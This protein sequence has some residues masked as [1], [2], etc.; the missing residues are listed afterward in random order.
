MEEKKDKMKS[1]N[2]N[3]CRTG[4]DGSAE[5]Q[6]YQAGILTDYEMQ[7]YKLILDIAPRGLKGANY[8]LRLG[9]GHYVF[10]KAKKKK[11]GRWSTVWLDQS[12]DKLEERNKLNPPF[13]YAECL[14]IDPF[15]AA[16]IQLKEIVDTRT[17]IENHDLLI[18]G[19]FDLK[20]SMVA[21]G[22]ISQQATQVEPN[23]KGKLF[24]YLFNQTAGPIRLN[25]EEEIA[26]IEFS[27]VSCAIHDTPA[28][29][30]ALIQKSIVSSHAKY[31]KKDGHNGL[32]LFCTEYGIDDVRYFGPN[33]DGDRKLPDHGSSFTD[34]IDRKI[35]DTVNTKLIKKLGVILG[36]IIALIAATSFLGVLFG[37][38][39]AG[40]YF[41]GKAEDG[42]AQYWK[43]SAPDR[44]KLL[45]EEINKT[46]DEE[47]RKRN[48]L[49]QRGQL[50]HDK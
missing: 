28:K 41:R 46:I 7:Q 50:N 26:T 33:V 49:K 22:L 24:C 10:M 47:L 20:L 17:C 45:R 5:G 43:V 3:G 1:P 8:N 12:R 31:Q 42:F 4:A 19:R 38:D 30:S 18:C 36:V 48:L 11:P 15:S 39:W 14:I 21:K 40:R 23:Y 27:Y 35:N 34:Y 16:L 13:K 32:R 25:Y 37:S 29:K 6:I 9:E 2:P 44:D